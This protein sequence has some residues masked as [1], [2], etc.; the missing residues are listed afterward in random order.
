MITIKWI[1]AQ[2]DTK[3]KTI[4]DHVQ[5][6]SRALTQSQLVYLKYFVDD[7]DDPKYN[8]TTIYNF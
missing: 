8:F 3:K 4:T 1:Q 2:N 5:T 7:D 6:I